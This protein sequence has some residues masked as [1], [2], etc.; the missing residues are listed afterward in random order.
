[1][2]WAGGWVSG[3][4]LPNKNEV[5]A[6]ACKG[7]GGGGGGGGGVWNSQMNGVAEYVK[8]KTDVNAVKLR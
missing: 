7:G 8:Q 6:Q 2:L 3:A 4:F 1:M 5:F